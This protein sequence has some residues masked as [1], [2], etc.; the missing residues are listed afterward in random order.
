MEIKIKN[1]EILNI[2]PILR[3]IYN[4]LRRE[5]PNLDLITSA[6][7]PG[8]T[9]VHGQMPVRGIDIRCRDNNLGGA[10]EKY[11]NYNWE[12]DSLRPGMVVALYHNA[13]SG[14]HI[15]L[16]CHPRTRRR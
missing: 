9:G 7:R 12:Y 5:F 16:Q 4:D 14:Y 2:Y 1:L 8:D 13:G 10:V 3:E 11:L 6:Y 15:H